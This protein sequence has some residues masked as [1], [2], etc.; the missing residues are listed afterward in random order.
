MSY[1]L[2]ITARARQDIDRNATWWANHHSV[3]QALNWS[4]TVYDQLDALCEFP[5]GCS[6]SPENDKYPIELRDKLVELG[7]RPRYRAVFTVR[8]HE[9]IVL[10]VRAAE[11]DALR[12]DDL[13][14]E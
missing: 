6:L 14:V 5:F 13:A 12:N 11:Q 7:S 9:V 3:D 10:A 4:R 8:E 1:R 2:R